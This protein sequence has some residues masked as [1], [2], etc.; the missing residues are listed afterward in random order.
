VGKSKS[1]TAWWQDLTLERGGLRARKTGALIPLSPRNLVAMG[2]GF[3]NYT[4]TQGL[5]LG[6]SLGPARTFRIAFLPDRPQPWH[7]IW[8]VLHAGGGQIVSDPAMADA[9][10]YFEDSTA[11]SDN[12]LAEVLPLPDSLRRINCNCLDVSKSKVARVFEDVF[13]YALSLDP[14]QWQGEAVEKSELNGAHD[15]RVI[16][17]PAERRDGKVYEHVI[18]NSDNGQFIEDFRTPM[19]GGE[20]ALVYIKQRAMC[21]RFANTNDRVLLRR[22]EQIFSLEERAKLKEFCQAMQLDWGGLDVLRDRNSGKIYVVDVNK[23]DMGPPTALP[24]IEQVR[25]VRLLSRLLRRYM[26]Q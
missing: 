10:F 7:L 8:S 21:Y 25:S 19:V 5:R 4:A 17:C 26:D 12:P 18:A 16:T 20:I 9:V 2:R 1:S 6:A 15:G 14:T 24:L 22:P 13:G 11:R 23:T 3:A